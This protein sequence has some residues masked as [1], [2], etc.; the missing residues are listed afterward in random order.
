MS[1][2]FFFTIVYMTLVRAL[3]C[4]VSVLYE[5]IFHPHA[6][7][8][9]VLL[10]FVS[11]LLFMMCRIW[12][13]QQIVSTIVVWIREIGTLSESVITL[14]AIFSFPVH[15]MCLWTQTNHSSCSE[16]LYLSS[17]HRPS[18]LKALLL[19]S[20]Q[21]QMKTAAVW[22]HCIFSSLQDCLFSE[23]SFCPVYIIGNKRI[24]KHWYSAAIAFS[25]RLPLP[26]TDSCC[27][28]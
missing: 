3:Q 16:N 1:S 23:K 11:S 18:F 14:K 2:V 26:E 13:P 27:L 21:L 20:Y 24:E 19:S 10:F 12:L 8:S 7:V 9:R 28:L 5:K 25:Q 22:P 4:F 17:S 15:G 6:L